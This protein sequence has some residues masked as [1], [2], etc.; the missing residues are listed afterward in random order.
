[1]LSSL[2][3]GGRFHGLPHDAVVADAHEVDDDSVEVSDALGS[4]A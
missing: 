2:S 3:F 1:V 4:R